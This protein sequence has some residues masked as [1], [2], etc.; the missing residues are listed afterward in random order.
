MCVYASKNIFL[1]TKQ[2]KT[3]TRHGK[4]WTNFSNLY[5]HRVPAMSNKSALY[6]KLL[7]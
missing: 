3:D 6:V 7:Y 1:K 2:G 5:K 4:E